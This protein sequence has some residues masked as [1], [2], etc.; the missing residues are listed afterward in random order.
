MKWEIGKS[1]KLWNQETVKTRNQEPPQHTDSHPW[2]RPPS[3]GHERT[4]GTRANLG[5]HPNKTDH[6]GKQQW[7]SAKAENHQTQSLSTFT[8]EI[9]QHPRMQTHQTLRICLVE[10][11]NKPRATVRT[12]ANVLLQSLRKWTSCKPA[13]INYLFVGTSRLRVR[14]TPRCVLHSRLSQE[15]LDSKM[16]LSFHLLMGNV[17]LAIVIGSFKPRNFV[18]EYNYDTQTSGNYELPRDS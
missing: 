3:W 6:S 9:I 8:N 4:W 11:E 18:S 15:L 5:D 13:K 14:E 2:T 12:S 16:L 17:K 10:A 7:H 1:L